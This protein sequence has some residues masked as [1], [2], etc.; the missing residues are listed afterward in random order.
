M[1]KPSDIKILSLLPVVGQPRHSKRIDMLLEAGFNVEAIAFDRPYHK[2]RIPNVFVSYLGQIE[3]GNYAKRLFK[4]LAALPKLRDAISKSDVIYASGGDMAF[5]AAVATAFT[6]KKIIMEIGD[7]RSAQ[8]KKGFVAGMHRLL[9]KYITSRSSFIVSTTEDFVSQ[10]YRKIINTDIDALVI[11]N[12]Q[13]KKYDPSSSLP[14][15]P[16]D[17][18]LTIGCFGLIRCQRSWDTLQAFA[19]ANLDKK[20]IV[21]GY[22]MLP[23][24]LEADILEHTNIEF[25]GSYKSPDDLASLYNSVD[26]V[27]GCGP[28]PVSCDDRNWVWA[29]SNRFY[30]SANY[31]TP[32]IALCGSGDG[33]VL[34]KLGLGTCVGA[35]DMDMAADVQRL[36]SI[37]KDDIEEWKANIKGLDENIYVLTDEKNRLRDRI[38]KLLS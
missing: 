27:W 2:G 20:L 6:G 21:A 37:S 34:E 4:M 25:L 11:E 28:Y 3:H 30:E 35:D 9:D 12:K 7:I 18:S 32:L 38:L 22:S 10:Y 13:E 14:Q 8:V 5:L 26:V 23:G 33:K 15:E 16:T 36:S 29:R 1:I 17:W 19:K 31:Q 24:D